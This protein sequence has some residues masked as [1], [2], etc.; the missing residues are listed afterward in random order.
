MNF[1]K[2]V[3][4]CK[5]KV[6]TLIKQNSE[7]ELYLLLGFCMFV[8]FFLF[9]FFVLGDIFWRT[10]YQ[11]LQM[12]PTLSIAKKKNSFYV[13]VCL[14]ACVGDIF[15]RTG[16][17]L[18]QMW[19]TLSTAKKYMHLCVCLSVSVCMC[20]LFC[21]DI[22]SL[23]FVCRRAHTAW[24]QKMNSLTQWMLLLISWRKRRKR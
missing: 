15:W 9:L 13:C 11:L 20:V 2:Y 1:N 10:G 17:Q 14:C 8:F 16:Y 24:S 22:T 19:P 3:M 6:F 4:K 7:I 23:L 12:W 5:G 18:L 21:T